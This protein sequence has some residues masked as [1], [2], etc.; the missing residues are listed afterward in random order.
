MSLPGN[1]YWNAAKKNTA[2]NESWLIQLY[3][4]TE[5]SFLGLSDKTVEISSNLYHGLVVDFG[6][7][8]DSIDLAKSTAKTES[9]TITVVN[10][11]KNGFLSEELFGGSRDYINR[12]VNIYS[13][14]GDADDI[15]KCTWI[16]QFRLYNIIQSGDRLKLVLEKKTPVDYISIP[17]DKYNGVYFPVT[18]GDFQPVGTKTMT[19]LNFLRGNDSD[20]SSASNHRWEADATDPPTFWDINTTVS[21]KLYIALTASDIMGI[22]ISD[23]SIFS[24]AATAGETFNISFKGR[25]ASGSGA[26]LYIG[27][28]PTDGTSSPMVQATTGSE[29]TYTGT[30]ELGTSDN[31]FYIFAVADVG[32]ASQAFEIDDL[33]VTLTGT[34]SITPEINMY[35][36]EFLRS[37]GTEYNFAVG[38]SAGS[39]AGLY[40]YDSALNQLNRLNDSS[41][42]TSAIGDGNESNFTSLDRTIYIRPEII[43]AGG[44]TN[45]ENINDGDPSTFANVTLTGTETQEITVAFPQI[46]ENV[47]SATLYIKADVRATMTSTNTATCYVGVNSTYTSL[48]NLYKTGLSTSTNGIVYTTIGQ[49]TTYDYDSGSGSSGYGDVTVGARTSVSAGSDSSFFRIYDMYYLVVL[50]PDYTSDENAESI[51]KEII[52]RPSGR[53]GQTKTRKVY[54]VRGESNTI[55]E[56]TTANICVAIDGLTQSYTGGSGLA[57]NVHEVYRDLLAR[58]TGFDVGDASLINWSDLDTARSDWSVRWWQS[59]VRSLASILKQLQYEGCFIFKFYKSGG[60]FIFIKDNPAGDSVHTI[61]N[62]DID[63]AN[64]ETRISEFADLITHTEYNWH[65]HPAKGGYIQKSTYTNSTS[66]TNYWASIATEENKETVNLDFLVKDPYSGSESNPNDCIALYY[67]NIFAKPKIIV[68][69]NIINKDMLN[70]ETGDIVQFDSE[71][72]SANSNRTIKAYGFDFADLYFMITDTRRSP[73]SLKIEARE[74][75]TI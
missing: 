58:F 7:V 50:E 13:R 60:K 34:D 38:K 31:H 14:L 68:K 22:R 28:H 10:Q 45:T 44:W 53:V 66:R 37:G 5:S 35:P 52:L 48:S 6:V 3:Y 32:T 55:K 74:V 43:S 17:Q 51:K 49:N 70:L 11:F 63:Q 62:N 47:A 26:K 72:V 69:C 36:C 4:D 8:N 56:Y 12:K 19:S 21:G 33:E 71:T 67:D 54:D 24:D 30:C 57:E 23:D 61:G 39:G 27:G 9:V 75:Y 20:M 64:F 2:I 18:Y 65:R 15:T 59:D 25:T 40:L 46:V 1:T 41:S 29:T 42:A 16:D 73:G